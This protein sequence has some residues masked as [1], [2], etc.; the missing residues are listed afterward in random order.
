MITFGERVLFRPIRSYYG[1]SNRDYESKVLLGHY[2]GTQSRN[3][4][5][6]VMTREGASEVLGCR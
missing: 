1:H 2:V 4:D 5:V 3:A 6:L